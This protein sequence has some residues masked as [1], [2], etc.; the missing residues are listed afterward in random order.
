MADSKKVPSIVLRKVGETRYAVA[1]KAPESRLRPFVTRPDSY[2]E[3]APTSWRKRRDRKP[4]SHQI[5]RGASTSSKD[6]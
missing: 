5:D 2:R 3:D 1:E 4:R 6:G